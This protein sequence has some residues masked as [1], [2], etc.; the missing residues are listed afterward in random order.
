MRDI[1]TSNEVS[2]DEKWKQ[3]QT[4][5][6][7]IAK[8]HLTRKTTKKKSW[9]TSEILDLMEERRKSKN[10]KDEYKTLH[11]TIQRKI[12]EAKEEYLVYIVR[13]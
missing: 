2:V 5:L 4:G 10:N 7:T 8:K 12:K 9:I 1:N 13:K 6:E 11:K 3:I